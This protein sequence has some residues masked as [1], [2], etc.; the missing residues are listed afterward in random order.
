MFLATNSS[1]RRVGMT[2]ET[3]GNRSNR[4]VSSSGRGRRE[5]LLV[6]GTSDRLT[7]RA[8]SVDR[9]GAG[10]L[11]SS[12]SWLLSSLSGLFSRAEGP[13][14]STLCIV[15]NPSSRVSPGTPH[16]SL[17]GPVLVLSTTDSSRTMSRGPG[18][19]WGR[20]LPSKSGEGD[21]ETRGQVNWSSGG[22]GSL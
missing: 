18:R 20:Q 19:A 6:R 16:L 9:G 8:R 7:G 1:V 12:A 13:L 22:V 15:V 10:A 17:F 2:T 14:I 21:G 4:V 11:A 5:R 3:A